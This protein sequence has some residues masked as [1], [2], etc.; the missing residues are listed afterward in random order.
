MSLLANTVPSASIW[1]LHC[2]ASKK[3]R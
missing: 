2:K 1:K 3:C